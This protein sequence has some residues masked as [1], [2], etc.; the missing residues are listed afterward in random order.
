MA[1]ESN[2]DA[3]LDKLYAVPLDEFTSTRNALAKELGSHGDEI[4][5]LKKP[6]LAAWALNQLARRHATELD[7]LFSVTDKLRHAQRRVMSGGKASDLRG[8]TDARNKVASRLTKLAEKILTE[9]GH[10]ASPST[11]SAAGDSFVAVASNDQGAELLRSGR[12]T[13]ELTP[14]SVVDVGSLTLVPQAEDDAADE[15]RPDRSRLKE[16]RAARD[17]ARATLKAARDAAKKA[18]TEA[19]RLE[20]EADDAAKRAKSAAEKAD[21][22]IRAAEARKT[23]VEEAERAVQE[24]E[25]AV[26][27]AEN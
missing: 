25:Q 17:E 4:K 20:I 9:A 13:R 27:A 11:L 18:N 16:A 24:A 7:E 6:N 14:G 19:T 22:A 2:V 3:A 12:L 5:T 1:A 21:F 15:P 10:A 23:D 8:A 26:R